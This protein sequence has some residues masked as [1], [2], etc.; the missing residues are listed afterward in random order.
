[1]EAEYQGEVRQRSAVLS[2]EAWAGLKARGVME[3]R[4]ASELC[5]FLLEKYLALEEKPVYAMPE[6]LQARQRSIYVSDVTWA[7]VKAIAVRQRRTGSHVLEQLI[8]GYLGL[9]L[10]R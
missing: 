8:R 2:D 10:E 6:G 9:E 7:E 3:G 1:M 4:S 5:Q